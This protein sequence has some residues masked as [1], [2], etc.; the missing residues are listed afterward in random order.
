VNN[1]L[2][3]ILAV[4]LLQPRLSYAPAQSTAASL[5]KFE[6]AAIR[7]CETSVGGGA[8]GR[9]DGGGG[10]T[11]PSPGRLNTNCQTVAALIQMAYVRFANGRT[12]GPLHVRISGGPAWIN[13][14]RY[15]INAKAEGNAS[16]E[17]MNGPMLQALLEDRFSLKTHRETREVPVYELTVAKGGAKLQTF[18]EGSC[19]PADTAHSSAPP[20]RDEK[21][22]CG[23]GG[24]R[25]TG[26]ILSLEARGVSLSEFSTN[27]L[28]ILDRPVINKTDILGLFDFH[29]EFSP[30][31]NTP[32]LPRLASANDLASLSI[33]TAVQQQ[34]GLRL[35]AAKG[36]GE[37]LVIDSIKKP[38][39]N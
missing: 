29:L 34:L 14:E 32:A 26:P 21:P 11:A 22:R 35:A 9:T 24:I 31:E 36:P 17:T 20:A 37:I 39:E 5:Q 27:T 18:K 23:L 33:F 3:A 13:S 4:A 30:D 10:R 15:D 7:H 19:T 2:F 16:K 25:I 8:G 12:D 6:V 38:S 28:S 1:P